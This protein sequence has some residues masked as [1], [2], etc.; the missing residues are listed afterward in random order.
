M[1]INLDTGKTPI[2]HD[3]LNTK[4]TL[5]S[6]VTGILAAISSAVEVDNIPVSLLY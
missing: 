4:R 2:A 1:H 3:G 5:H 6:W